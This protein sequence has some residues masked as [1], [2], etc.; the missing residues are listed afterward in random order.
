MLSI[1]DEALLVRRASL[2]G[3]VADL[4]M[5]LSFGQHEFPRIDSGARDLYA[6]ASL[7]D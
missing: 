4:P 1:S 3:Q 7:Y 2:V 6:R 5:Y